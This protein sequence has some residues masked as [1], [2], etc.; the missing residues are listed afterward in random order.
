M[1][2]D[3]TIYE[4]P[5]KHCTYVLG[6]DVAEG[7]RAAFSEIVVMKNDPVEIVAHF[8]SN[9]IKPLEFGVKIWLVGAFYFNALV[10][11]ERNSVGQVVLD[12]LEHGHPER[13]KYPQIR[14]YPN[15][16]Y[17]T[18]I[19]KKTQEETKRLGFTTGK[20][21]KK[22]AI[23]R[24]AELVADNEILLNSVRLCLQMEGFEENPETG[25]Y[26]QQHR[27][28]ISL[29]H[30]DDGIMAAAICNEM[31]LH[32]FKNRFFSQPERGDW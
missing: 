7:I 19:D 2:N 13:R 23:N 20:H 14:R 30:A 15:L 3:L 8:F 31:R 26:N 4:L 28:P 10:G 24:F 11:V 6:A 12:V 25:Q 18:R 22:R 27:D 1:A 17:E 9:T 5:H 21:S 16:Y 29:Y 32:R